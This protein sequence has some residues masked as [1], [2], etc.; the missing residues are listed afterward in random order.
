MRAGSRPARHAD[1][2]SNIP[3]DAPEVTMPASA[4]VTRAITRQAPA[5]NS[6]MSTHSVEAATIA[7]A[8]SGCMRPP[9]S[10][11]TVPQALMTVGT[12]KFW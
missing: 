8:T 2:A 3:A 10:R 6:T 9:D 4:P 12:P 5:C 7:A 11:V 1:A